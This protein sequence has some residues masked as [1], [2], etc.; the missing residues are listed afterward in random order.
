MTDS[1][2]TTQDSTFI[3]L[4]TE[5]N[6]LTGE[7]IEEDMMTTDSVQATVLTVD[8]MAEEEDLMTGDSHQ[9]NV[10][11]NPP[12][13]YTRLSTLAPRTTPRPGVVYSISIQYLLY[14]V[15]HQGTTHL[16]FSPS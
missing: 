16:R 10:T 4:T 13:A 9:A 1:G 3:S 15:C 6:N 7:E 12:A 8:K 11:P 14:V 5:A 2:D